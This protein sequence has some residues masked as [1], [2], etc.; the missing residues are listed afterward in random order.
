MAV[1]KKKEYFCDY[2]NLAV[3]KLKKIETTILNEEEIS[4]FDI[5]LLE[6]SIEQIKC[7]Y[8]SYIQTKKLAENIVG[9]KSTP[10]STTI[11]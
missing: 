8:N 2:K 7:E 10:Y 5:E 9:V 6:F 11:E 1:D 4:D 3:E